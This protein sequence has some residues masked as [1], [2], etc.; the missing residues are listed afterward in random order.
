MF[1]LTKAQF[2]DITKLAALH[3]GAPAAMT[4]AI[5]NFFATSVCNSKEESF[6][7]QIDDSTVGLDGA[8][9]FNV[10][11]SEKCSAM[12]DEVDMELRV[13]G[14]VEKIAAKYSLQYLGQ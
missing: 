2:D 3:R 11:V 5:C 9:D 6:V 12:M 14:E 4:R 8:V 10:E 7:R 1:A 13:A